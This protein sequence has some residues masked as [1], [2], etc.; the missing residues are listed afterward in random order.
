MLHQERCMHAYNIMSTNKYTVKCTSRTQYTG[1]SPVIL[2]YK[3]CISSGFRA[4][5]FNFNEYNSTGNKVYGII[6][7]VV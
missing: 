2:H 1:Y 3:Y 6:M 5:L 7:D 4:S